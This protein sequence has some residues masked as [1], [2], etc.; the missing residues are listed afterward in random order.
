[1]R[2]T[3]ASKVQTKAWVLLY[4]CDVSKALHTEIVDSSTSTA[5]INAFHSCFSVRNTPAQISTDPGTCF[6]GAKTKC[7]GNLV[8]SKGM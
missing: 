2:P 7:K 1:M 5:I 8:K 6:V 4:L 3:L